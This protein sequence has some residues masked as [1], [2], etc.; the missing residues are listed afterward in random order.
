MGRYQTWN[1]ELNPAAMNLI[2]L[3]LLALAIAVTSVSVAEAEPFSISTRTEEIPE[4]GEVARTVLRTTTCEFSFIPPSGWKP[5]I[6]A[7]SSTITWTSKDYTTVLRLKIFS[8]GSEKHPPLRADDLRLEIHREMPGASVSQEFTCYTAGSSGLAFDLEQTVNEK[9]PA[10]SRFAFI[11]CAGGR[12]RIQ[13]TTTREEFATRQNDFTRF[14]NS[15]RIETP[16]P[17]KTTVKSDERS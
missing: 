15:F 9:F 14:L 10:S 12:V 5:Q 13:L 17:D 2:R 8:D 1:C 4:S 3:N 16:T 6:D 11:P 7:P